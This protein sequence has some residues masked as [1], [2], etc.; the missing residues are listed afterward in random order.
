MQVLFVSHKYPPS[1]GGMEKQSFELVTGMQAHCTVHLLVL[2]EKEGRLGFF[3]NLERRI[4]DKIK[5]Y[6]DISVVHF[7]DALLATVALGHKT[8]KHLKR[9]VTVH[10]LDVVFPNQKYQQD[11]LPK[12]NQFDLIIAVSDATRQA[13]MVRGIQS[14]KVT[15]IPNGVAHDLAHTDGRFSKIELAQKFNF[16]PDKRLLVAMGRSVKR[17]G[18]SWFVREVMPLLPTDFHLLIIGPFEPKAGFFERLLAILPQKLANQIELMLGFPTDQKPLRDLLNGNSRV[19]H[20]GRLPQVD[21]VSVLKCADAFVMP[22][23]QVAGDMEGFGLVCLEA[24]LAGAPVF[25][26]G[27]DG[28]TD[29]II[30]HKNGFLLPSGNAQQWADS[31]MR[32]LSHPESLR[33]QASDF[34]KFTLE[35]YSWALMVERYWQ[36]ILQSRK[37]E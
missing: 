31:L 37:S 10:G 4:N 33:A 18:F 7:N 11:L 28:I 15:T 17:K 6:P 3:W 12:F 26:A 24:A 32:K 22:N 29:A 34:Q 35:H 9:V 13:C 19:Q 27:I 20:L 1:T 30:D 2:G 36:A 8:Y 21:M 16:N 23:L 25:A 5:Q 14:D